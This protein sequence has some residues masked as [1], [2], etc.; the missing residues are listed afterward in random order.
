LLEGL[1]AVLSLVCVMMISRNSPLVQSPPNAIY[2]AGVGSLLS[3]FG[4]P[5]AF[6]VSFALMAFTTFVY[7]TLDVC[8]RLGRYI[9]Q[10]LT[11]WNGAAGRWF[12]TG[13]TALA[14]L[15]FLLRPTVYRSDMASLL[16][17][18]RSEQS[19]PRRADPSLR[20]RMALA[21]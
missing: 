6:A 12:A 15:V 17:T 8:T 18:L 20:H 14:P 21:N 13:I 7:D 9:V 1:T 2:A 16:A 5:A 10:E 4:V 11:G 3:T 19:A